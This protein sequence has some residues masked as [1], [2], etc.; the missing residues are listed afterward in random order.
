[1]GKLNQI[2]KSKKPLVQKQ[3]NTKPKKAVNISNNQ[4]IGIGLL[5]LGIILIGY[6]I[7]T[8]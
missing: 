4:L 1:M 5:I 2:V 8:W 7:M 3:P 6:A